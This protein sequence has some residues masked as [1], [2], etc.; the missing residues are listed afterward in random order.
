LLKGFEQAYA[1]R[2]MVGLPENLARAL[3]DG[4][5]S[6]LELRVRLG[7]AAAT[8]E[9]IALLKKGDAAANERIAIARTLGEVK[10]AESLGPLLEVSG[11]ATDAELQ[12]AAL[13][14]VSAFADPAIGARLLGEFSKFSDEVRPA[15]FDLMLSRIEWTRQLAGGISSGAIAPG[16][17]PSD[18]ADQLRRHPD[19]AIAVLAKHTFGAGDSPNPADSKQQ[20]QQLRDVL[21]EGTGNPYAGE[22]IFTKQ[23]A[24][25]HKLFHKGGK[26][27]PDLTPYQRGNLETLLTSVITPSAEIR[28]GFEYVTV[29]TMDGRILSGFVTDQDTQI[30]TLRGKAGEDIRIQR[31]DVDSIAPVGRSLMPDGLLQGMNDQELRDFFA[32]LRISQPISQ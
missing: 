19:A 17:I 30:V 20:I 8:S 25:C 18:V 4:G 10:A 13:T 22:A 3:V 12:R 1:G 15:F 5:R 24:A 7:D 11:T 14:A 23:C 6:S 29:L 31:E 9:A 26:I 2:R 21:A 16:A 28:E 32:Y 27:G